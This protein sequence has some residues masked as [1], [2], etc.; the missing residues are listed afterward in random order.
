MRLLVVTLATIENELEACLAAIGR[1]THTDYEHLVFRNLPNREAHEALYGTFMD[2]R[3]E[4]DLLV[5]VDADMVLLSPRLLEDV[6][7]RFTRDSDLEV[8]SIGVWDFYTDR[9][10]SGLNSY[11]NT[12]QWTRT[13]D[14]VFTDQFPALVGRAV[15]DYSDLAPAASH[16]PDPHP[17]QA[18]HFG[19]HR[20]VKARVALQRS[21][22]SD[23]YVRYLDIERTWSHYLRRRDRRLALAVL[24]GELALGGRFDETQLD[25]GNADVEAVYT[26]YASCD[27]ASLESEIRRARRATWGILPSR[28]RMEV[29]RGDWLSLP[30]RWVVPLAWRDR[31]PAIVRRIGRRWR[32]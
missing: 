6:D 17:F 8:L 19:V 13:G 21:M 5:K 22:S 31:V 15:M 12:L 4:F 18:F 28:L 23:Y 1:Q 7:A 32:P 26:S 14:L 30:L 16:C 27:A 3:D 11:R 25:C 29:L 9:L 10:V 24:G 20:G 2:R